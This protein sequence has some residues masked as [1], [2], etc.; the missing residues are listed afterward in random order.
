[1]IHGLQDAH[2]VADVRNKD[3]PEP[4]HDLLRGTREVR[5]NPQSHERIVSV[6]CRVGWF[7]QI[8]THFGLLLLG[9]SGCFSARHR[10]RA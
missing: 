2:P 8:D 6:P 7:R 9:P 5:H 1:M 3:A 10:A 4:F